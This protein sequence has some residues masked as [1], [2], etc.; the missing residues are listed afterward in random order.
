MSG[1][2]VSDT[3]TKDEP[4][5]PCRLL[6]FPP[7]DSD[8]FWCGQPVTHSGNQSICS[9]HNS[10]PVCGDGAFGAFPGFL[11]SCFREMPVARRRVYI[12]RILP[13]SS[14]FP[15]SSGLTGNAPA[16]SLPT[17]PV[18]TDVSR[19]PLDSLARLRAQRRRPCDAS[20]TPG[21]GRAV[22]PPPERSS[23]SF[24]SFPNET[25]FLP[26][27]GSCN[28]ATDGSSDPIACSGLR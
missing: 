28:R 19:I 25:H 18:W 8:L 23:N 24:G 3:V 4:L 20:D 10:A 13:V 1:P 2:Q 21:R 11:V 12:K 9:S 16:S 27:L 22:Y 26:H 5:L 17:R 7:T 15:L 14:G 6:V